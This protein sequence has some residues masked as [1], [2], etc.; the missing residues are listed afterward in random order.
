MHLWYGV[1]T[2]SAPWVATENSSDGKIKA[3]EYAVLSECFQC[4]LGTCRCEA[5]GG[6]GKRGD[7]QLIKPDHQYE[8]KDQNLA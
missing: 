4:V 7:A 8:R 2:V 3:L 1:I 5:A 6:W